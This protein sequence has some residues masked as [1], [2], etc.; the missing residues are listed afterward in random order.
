MKKFIILAPDYSENF[1]GPIALHKLC[2]IIN[3]NNGVAY[4]HPTFDSYEIN[5]TNFEEVAFNVLHQKR[6]FYSNFSFTV[7]PKYQTP[8]RHILFDKSYNEDWVAVYPEVT[9]GNPLNMKNV[10]RW[11]LHN[12]GFHSKKIFYGENEIHFRHNSGF[13]PFHYPGSKLSDRFLHVVDYDL[14]LYNDIGASEQRS[15]SAFC[16]RKG[17]DRPIQHDL[18]GSILIDGKSHA[19]IAAIFKKVKTFYSYDVNTAYSLLAVLCGC[20]SVVFP[21]PGVSEFEWNPDPR[22]RYGIAYGVDNIAKA[23]ATSH[24]VKPFLTEMNNDSV[25]C[26]IDFIAE[27]N[28]YFS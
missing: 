13:K 7:N 15:G 10:V 21:T 28:A 22:F 26:V 6:L 17:R 18:N 5:M 23:K 25:N 11:L 16:L 3:R 8:V 24:L 14:D 20:D 19:E 27:V 4:L 12:P 9:L 1:G 2:D